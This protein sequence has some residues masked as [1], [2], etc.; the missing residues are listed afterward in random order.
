MLQRFEKDSFADLLYSKQPKDLYLIAE[1]VK[2]HPNA[3]WTAGISE[4][5]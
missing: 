5:I 3:I 4:I 1:Y 2:N